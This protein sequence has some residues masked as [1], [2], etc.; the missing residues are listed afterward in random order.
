MNFLYA[1]LI[2]KLFVLLTVFQIK[3]FL[4]DY[5]LQGNYMLGKFKPGWDFVK[6]LLAHVGVHM[7]FTFVILLVFCPWLLWCQIVGLTLLDGVIHFVMDRIKAGPKYLGRYKTV[8]KFQLDAYTEIE[9]MIKAQ[10]LPESIK[11]EDERDF[12]L[13]NLNKERNAALKETPYFWWSL[14]L[15]QMVHHL[16]HYLIVFIAILINLLS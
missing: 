13:L 16:T 3:H 15:D 11:D 4:A 9:K 8:N 6:P 2:F 14:G 10:P 7:A 1:I 5:P 12:M